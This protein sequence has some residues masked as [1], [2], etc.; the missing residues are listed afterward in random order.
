MTTPLEQ[1]RAERD[2]TPVHGRSPDGWV[3]VERDATA[4]SACASAKTRCASSATR[5]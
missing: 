5:N 2:S 3:E 4:R 1:F